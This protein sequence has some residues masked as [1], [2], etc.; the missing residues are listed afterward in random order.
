M[1][2]IKEAVDNNGGKYVLFHCP[3]CNEPHQIRHA[4]SGSVWVWNGSSEN[5]TFIPSVLVT[6]YVMDEAGYDMIARGEKPLDGRYPGHEMCCHSYVNNGRIQF[7][8]D[9]THP[10][11]GQT[12]DLPEWKE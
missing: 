7:L 12:V 2:K 8:S 6:G 3:G 9:C 5:P 10:L 1:S 4:G 11:A